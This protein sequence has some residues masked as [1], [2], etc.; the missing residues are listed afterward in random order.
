MH[1]IHIE[2][3]LQ[4]IPFTIYSLTHIVLLYRS[5]KPLEGKMEH[6]NDGFLSSFQLGKNTNWDSLFCARIIMDFFITN[7]GDYLFRVLINL[8]LQHG[9]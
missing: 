6:K 9:I 1:D 4:Q 7:E 3:F 8:N 2:A 5:N